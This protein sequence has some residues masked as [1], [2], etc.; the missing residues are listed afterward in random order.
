VTDYDDIPDED[1]GNVDD[2]FDAVPKKT[3]DEGMSTKT[4]KWTIGARSA[5]LSGDQMDRVTVSVITKDGHKIT[6]FTDPVHSH[7]GRQGIRIDAL[8]DQMKGSGMKFKDFVV[9]KSN[10]K[11]TSKDIAGWQVTRYEAE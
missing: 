7:G 9:E 8:K 10:G 1:I 4:T 2:F 5:A 11:F 3:K 6:I